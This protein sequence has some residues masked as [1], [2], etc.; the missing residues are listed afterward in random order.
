MPCYPCHICASAGRTFS[1]DCSRAATASTDH[2]GDEGPCSSLNRP[3]AERTVRR[4]STE[5]P[6]FSF[7][8]EPR[9]QSQYTRSH[10]LHLRIEWV[11][12]E[13]SQPDAALRGRTWRSR[14]RDYVATNFTR[15]N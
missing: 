5:S 13:P 1:V 6:P 10:R 8:A 2:G 4:P 12:H 3:Q 9:G 15:Y 11:L 7:V 14:I